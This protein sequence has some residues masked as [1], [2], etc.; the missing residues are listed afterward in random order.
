M[1]NFI[2][3]KI[4]FCIDTLNFS[5]YKIIN[6]VF[7]KIIFVSILLIIPSCKNNPVNSGIIPPTPIPLDPYNSPIWYPDGRFIGFNHAPLISFK[8]SSGFQH[9]DLNLD[10]AGFWLINSDGTNMHRIL[11]YYLQTPAWSPDG[12][13]IAFV[14]NA[15][16]FKMK[17]NGTNFDTTTLTQLTTQGRNFFPTWNSYGNLIAYNESVCSGN[18]SCGIW[19]IT[20]NGLQRSFIAPY[21][22]FPDWNPLNMDLIFITSAI[23]NSGEVLGDTLWIYSNAKQSKRFFCYLHNQ[24]YD[25]RYPKYS[26][27]GKSIAF[28]SQPLNQQVNLWIMDSSGTGLRQLTTDGMSDDSGEPFSWDATSKYIVFTKYQYNKETSQ[29]GTLWI[30]NVSTGQQRQLTVNAP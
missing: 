6:W 27:D 23:L 21:G 20:T 26:P 2:L 10:S 22:N 3:L 25:N 9:Y 11:P 14:A 15:Q 16:I 24:N 1:K 29:N 4:F 12:Q 13:W 5:K 8:D 30:I 28:S 18:S 19:L 7:I 17:F